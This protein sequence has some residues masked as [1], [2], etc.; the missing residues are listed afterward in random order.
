MRIQVNWGGIGAVLVGLLIWL[1]IFLIFCS[2]CDAQEPDNDPAYKLMKQA[3]YYLYIMD[4]G[5]TLTLMDKGGYVELNPFWRPYISQPQ[6]V[7]M[8]DLGVMIGTHYLYNELHEWNKPVSYL[9][10]GLGLA[11]QAYVVHNN[12]KLAWEQ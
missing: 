2:C 12:W 5:L 10:L 3:Y 9:V 4:T 8:L 6:L 7:L 1:V 11:A